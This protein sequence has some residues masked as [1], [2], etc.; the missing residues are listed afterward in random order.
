VLVRMSGRGRKRSRPSEGGEA[1]GE[2]D[3]G[4]A[5]DDATFDAASQLRSTMDDAA[6]E[7]ICPITQELPIDPVIAMD[8][9]VY[10]RKAIEQWIARGNG[11]SPMTN[12]P[13]TGQLLPATHVRN[14]LELMVKSGA[15]TGDKVDAWRKKIVDENRV[16][17]VRA[18]A[19]AGDLKAAYKLG[20]WYVFGLRG[21]TEN[22]TEGLNWLQKSADGGFAPGISEL[23][24]CYLA[25]IGT[26]RQIHLGVVMVTEAA[27]LGDEAACWI[28]GDMFRNGKYGAK[29]NE[30]VAAKWY[31]K[32]LQSE[33]IRRLITLR[34]ALKAKALE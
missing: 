11:K 4:S 34:V 27:Q 8:G 22:H 12:L 29:K 21:L 17:A 28:L 25:G 26:E 15:I 1:E 31:Q 10:E 2:D 3:L 13:M 14:S 9:K 6:S 19:V 30:V 5:V 24:H 7:F 23:G 33:P 18:K 20:R 32:F 16:E